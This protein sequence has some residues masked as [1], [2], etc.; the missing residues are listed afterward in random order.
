MNKLDLNITITAS[1]KATTA[2]NF[3]LTNNSPNPISLDKLCFTFIYVFNPDKFN[4]VRLLRHQGSYIELEPE[5]SIEL[6]PAQAWSFS[7]QVSAVLNQYSDMPCGFFIVK[8]DICTRV[9]YDKSAKLAARA[10]FVDSAASPSEVRSNSQDI[11]SR[12]LNCFP[13][14]L[15]ITHLNYSLDLSVGFNCTASKEFKHCWHNI[16]AIEQDFALSQPL[17]NNLN[18]GISLKIEC[19]A[20]FSPEAYQLSISSAGVKIRAADSQGVQHALISL[21]QIAVLNPAVVP[22]VIITDAPRFIWRAQHLDTARVYYTVAEIKRLLNQMALYKLNKFHWHLVDD[23]AWRLE[24]KALPQLCQKISQRGYRELVPP[25]YGSS[26]AASGG[27]YSPEQV[28]EV[29]AYAAARNIEVI[30]EIDIPGHCYALLKLLPELSEPADKSEYKSVQGYQN[31]CL[32]PALEAT[33]VFLETVFSEVAELFPSQYIHIGADERPAGSWEKSPLIG[34]L[35][36]R[37]GFTTTE[38]VQSYFLNKVQAMLAKLGKKTGAWEEA[39]EQGEIAK[40]G[41]IVSWKGVDA[42]LSAA[43]RG[44]QVGMSP[45]QYCYFDI[46]QSEHWDEPGLTWIDGRVDVQS[47]YSFNPIPPG[48]PTEFSANIIGVQGCLWSE[49]LYDKSIVE[50]QLF[51]RMIALS[52]VCWSQP[53]QKHYPSFRHDLIKYQLPLLSVLNINYRRRGL[54]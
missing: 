19:D 43:K 24:I 11:N 16:I 42:G 48:F 2:L 34:Q 41:Y 21:W 1:L 49:N 36:Q 9:V 28:R 31:N 35:M 53:A 26:A 4:N 15:D 17:F 52:E 22:A 38:Q 13:L 30:P 51:P 47:T 39:T 40:D 37:H 25:Q 29:I 46:A 18:Q 20:E 45:A 32:N 12:Q 54:G 23:E 10:A 44:Y 8:D 5:Q 33:Y 14:P 7:A 27:Y 50:H 3:T 6:A